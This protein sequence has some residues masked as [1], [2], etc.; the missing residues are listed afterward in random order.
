MVSGISSVFSLPTGRTDFFNVAEA[1]RPLEKPIVVLETARAALWRIGEG[2]VGAGVFLGRDARLVFIRWDFADE[3]SGLVD[4]TE[5]LLAGFA[6][7]A[8]TFGFESLLAMG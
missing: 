1:L 3:A 2:L 8:D 5:G 6:V 4:E 7:V